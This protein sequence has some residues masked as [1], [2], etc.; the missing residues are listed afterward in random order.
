MRS[1]STAG[2]ESNPREHGTLVPADLPLNV[3]AADSASNCITD[4]KIA[5]DSN[6]LHA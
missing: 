3:P 6:N 1:E 2:W 4:K 5:T